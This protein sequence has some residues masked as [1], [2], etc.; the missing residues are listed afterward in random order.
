[1]IKL[2]LN[3][4]DLGIRNNPL[5]GVENKRKRKRIWPLGHLG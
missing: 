2:V 5:E 1:M 3:Y 4:L